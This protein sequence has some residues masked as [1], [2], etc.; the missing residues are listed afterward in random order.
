MGS[1]PTT[2]TPLV[3]EEYY[4]LPTK[5]SKNAIRIRYNNSMGYLHREPRGFAN[6]GFTHQDI[7]SIVKLLVFEFFGFRCT[8]V[9]ELLATFDSINI[10]Q[11][12]N[13]T[14]KAKIIMPSEF[15]MSTMAFGQPIYTRV[16]SEGNFEQVQKFRLIDLCI[17]INKRFK[18]N[19]SQII[20]QPITSL[21]N[22]T[23]PIF[24]NLQRIKT[25]II[26]RQFIAPSLYD[27]AVTRSFLKYLENFESH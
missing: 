10:Y 8:N 19:I 27:F 11:V 26:F 17:F 18:C 22:K 4:L 20:R 14:D 7:Q 21:Y 6:N 9:T 23:Y 25:S 15:H 12:Q 2:V 5:R 24:Y 16:E 3:R 1:I 13:D